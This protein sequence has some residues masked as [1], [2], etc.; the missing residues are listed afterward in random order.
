MDIFVSAKL[1]LYSLEGT[2]FLELVR[3]DP[4]LGMPH[5]TDGT[6]SLQLFPLNHDIFA[7]LLKY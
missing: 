1:R 4:S 2:K 6:P 3:W 7:L 5:I